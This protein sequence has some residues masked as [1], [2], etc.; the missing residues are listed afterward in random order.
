MYEMRMPVN[1][2]WETNTR[3]TVTTL[4]K[5]NVAKWLQDLDIKCEMTFPSDIYIQNSIEDM[6]FELWTNQPKLIGEMIFR[7]ENKD[8]AML[9]K[10]TWS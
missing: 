9:F 5:Q 8:D 1:V 4:N 10:L 6:M 2:I 7:F 3:C